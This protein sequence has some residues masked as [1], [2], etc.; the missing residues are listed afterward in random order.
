MWR[1]FYIRIDCVVEGVK[2]KSDRARKLKVNSN[3]CLIQTTTKASTS[4]LID[5]QFTFV[6]HR[7]V[8]R[9]PIDARD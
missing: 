8:L 2:H 6:L 5:S 4:I 3:R 1:L 9:T 7:L